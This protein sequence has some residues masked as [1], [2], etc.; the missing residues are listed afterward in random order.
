MHPDL[1]PAA[2]RMFVE[3]P[4]SPG[5]AV[6]DEPE[7]VEEVSPDQPVGASDGGS[8]RSTVPAA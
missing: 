8:V 1:A 5:F 2:G 4:H 6:D 3:S 7:S